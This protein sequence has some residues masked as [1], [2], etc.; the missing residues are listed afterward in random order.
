[1]GMLIS[2]LFIGGIAFFRRTVKTSEE[3]QRITSLKCLATIPYVRFKARNTKKEKQIS[4]LDHRISYGYKESL[5]SLQIRLERIFHRE[6]QK[7]ILITSSVSG[8]GKTTVAINLAETLAANGR[9]VLLID[10]D[11]RK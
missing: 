3:M 10:G 5:R 9:K 2:I 7:V 1:M 6:R 11:L 4:I 8:E